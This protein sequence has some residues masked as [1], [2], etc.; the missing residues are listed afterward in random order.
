M[1]NDEK[2]AITKD[3]K[4]AITKKYFLHHAAAMGASFHNDFQKLLKDETLQLDL[5]DEV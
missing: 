2:D 3:E 1:M 4:Y 5:Q